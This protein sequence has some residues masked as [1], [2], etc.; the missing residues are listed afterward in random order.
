MCHAA[1]IYPLTVNQGLHARQTP[2]L[3]P[4]PDLTEPATAFP[5]YVQQGIDPA[6]IIRV[7]NVYLQ[8]RAAPKCLFDLNVS[9]T[10]AKTIAQCRE[11]RMLVA[12]PAQ[13]P[14]C[15]QLL[16]LR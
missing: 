7:E 6:R 3:L 12:L 11:A 10:E 9:T 2:V 15:L 1:L 5:L 8:A 13:W 16:C 4:F 14:F